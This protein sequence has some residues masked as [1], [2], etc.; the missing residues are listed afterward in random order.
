MDV[1]S[2]L[3]RTPLSEAV[4]TP[5]NLDGPILD[6][7][8]KTLNVGFHAIGAVIASSLFFEA[9]QLSPFA[10]AY[11]PACRCQ[12]PSVMPRMGNQ[13]SHWR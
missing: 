8:R 7:C 11:A 6:W 2:T 5:C 3:T 13:K 1:E 9:C 10:E 4:I 12:L